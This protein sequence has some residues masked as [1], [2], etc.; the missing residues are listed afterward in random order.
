MYFKKLSVI[1]VNMDKCVQKN[2]G[3][4]QYSTSTQKWPV[5]GSSFHWLI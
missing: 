2:T 1:S 4:E 3:A 5:V